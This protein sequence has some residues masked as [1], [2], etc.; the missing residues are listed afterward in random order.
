M[1]NLGFSTSGILRKSA[2]DDAD[3]LIGRYSFSSRCRGSNLRF[4]P[5]QFALWANREPLWDSRLA[6]ASVCSRKCNSDV[7]KAGSPMGF[8]VG[9][10]PTARSH[11][12]LHLKT[13]KSKDS[14]GSRTDYPSAYIIRVYR[15]SVVPPE[16]P[17]SGE[18]ARPQ[19]ETE[20]W[21][22]SCKGR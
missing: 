1:K 9:R 6:S 22:E 18:L 17:L 5:W 2:P 13:I 3:F 12:D 16:A 7:H 10:R 11:T 20:G 8:L 14:N 19:A 4:E 21:M 15:R